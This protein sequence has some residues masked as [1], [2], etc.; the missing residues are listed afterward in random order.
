MVCRDGKPWRFF[1]DIL[2]NAGGRSKAQSTFVREKGPDMKGNRARTPKNEFY[3][4]QSGY[5]DPTAGSV[6]DMINRENRELEKRKQEFE[7]RRKDM[8]EGRRPGKKKKKQ[9]RKQ[10]KKPKHEVSVVRYFE[11]YGGNK[12][13]G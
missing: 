10:A 13:E 3:M 5:L 2:Q 6:L 7:R 8:E 9:G 1:H 12:D 11:P 4:N